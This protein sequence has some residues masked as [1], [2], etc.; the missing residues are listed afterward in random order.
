MLSYIAGRE[1][2]FVS[3]KGSME[4]YNIHLSACIVP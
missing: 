3:K 1:E 2:A 4:Q